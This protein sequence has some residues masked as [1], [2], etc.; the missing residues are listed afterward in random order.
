MGIEYS[1]WLCSDC[2]ANNC[3]ETGDQARFL[4]ESEIVRVEFESTEFERCD[5]FNLNSP[6]T[7]QNTWTTRTGAVSDPSTPSASLV[8]VNRVKVRST[9]AADNCVNIVDRIRNQSL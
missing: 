3:L 9:N 6:T 4:R 5:E 2:T 1:R 7:Y 8:K